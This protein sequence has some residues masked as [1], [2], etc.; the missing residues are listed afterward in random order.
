[1]YLNRYIT[2]ENISLY[3]GLFI[4]LI[5]FGTQYVHLFYDRY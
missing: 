1:M 5:Q 2:Y 3:F 4:C